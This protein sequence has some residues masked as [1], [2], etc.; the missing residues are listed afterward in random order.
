MT[1]L[2][3]MPVAEAASYH[4]YDVVDYRAVERDYGS[5]DDLRALIAAAHERGIA[6]IVDMV[7]N[8]TSRE[9]PWFRDATTPGSAH[10]GWYVWATADPGYGGPDG[11]LVWHP[12]GER[13]YYGLFWEGVP[14]LNL[15]ND[16]VTAELHDVARFWLDEVG[17]DGFRLDAIRHLVEVG[18]DQVNTPATHAWLRD[19]HAA[20]HEAAPAALLLGEAWDFPLAASS[21]VPEDVDLVFEFSLAGATIDALRQER[22][23]PLLGARREVAELYLSGEYATF[24]TNHDQARVASQLREDPAKLRLAA[25]L[26]LTGPGVPFV[27]YGEEIGLTGRK[28]DEQIRTPMAWDG[29][30]PSAGFSAGTP[31]QPLAPGWEGR[32]VAAQAADPGSLLSAYRDLIRLR[33]DHPAL[34]LGDA[35]EVD[36]ASDA[37]VAS[38]RTTPDETLLVV[39]NLAAEPVSDYALGLA[40]GPLCGSPSAT[41]VHG[42]GSPEPP[43]V[44][45]GGGFSGYRPLASLPAH[46]LTVIALQP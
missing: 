42:G 40:A 23:G 28:P 17:V 13:F 22:A 24:L 35:L 26:L 36:A 9:H 38:L 18:R 25:G 31:W 30:A 29:T 37:V 19:Y 41:I 10:D 14:D 21:Y 2:W 8:H 46:G 6:V 34:R 15:A 3:L 43:R 5:V 12:A 16:E 39:A 33:A 20:V 45:A 7:L 32:N 11:Q 4:G 27:Y 44:E 1:G